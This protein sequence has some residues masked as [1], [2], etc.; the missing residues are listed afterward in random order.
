LSRGPVCRAMQ[1]A[2]GPPPLPPPLPPPPPPLLAAAAAAANP[3]AKRRRSAKP[4]AG[5]MV[6]DAAGLVQDAGDLDS[7]GK[8]PAE[9]MSASAS[10]VMAQAAPPP[11]APGVP[12]APAPALSRPAAP[13]R[14]DGK[15][16][17]AE[18]KRMARDQQKELIAKLDYLLPVRGWPCSLRCL[19]A[20]RAP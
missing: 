10:G 8:A 3:P 12:V 16:S 18:K 1:A 2:E 20:L 17:R 19:F 14:A 7:L 15:V 4:A 9:W 11:E 6:I 5:E 13:P